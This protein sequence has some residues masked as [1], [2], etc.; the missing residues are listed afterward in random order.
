MY[1]TADHGFMAVGAI[2]PQFYAELLRILDI[3]PEEAPQFPSQRWP[4]LKKR[5]ASVVFATKTRAEWTELF[6]TANACTTPVLSLQEAPT[7]RHH[8]ARNSFAYYH[9]VLLPVSAPRFGNYL[10]NVG[11]TPPDTTSTLAAWGIGNVGI[12][13]VSGEGDFTSDNIRHP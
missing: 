13:P 9:G 10:P 3:T 1:E 2:E 12:V 4:E 11:D 5:F 8:A 6:E 7:H